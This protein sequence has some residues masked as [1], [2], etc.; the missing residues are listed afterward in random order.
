M[1]GDTCSEPAGHPMTSRAFSLGL[2]PADI[3]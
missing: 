3:R 2:S 1:T